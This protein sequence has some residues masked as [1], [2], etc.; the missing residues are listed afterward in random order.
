MLA[1]ELRTPLGA[2]SNAVRVL[3]VSARRGQAGE[4]A[5]TR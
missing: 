4:R 2:I 5:R 3:E 1:H